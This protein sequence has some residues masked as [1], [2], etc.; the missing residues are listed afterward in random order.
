MTE[1]TFTESKSYKTNDGQVWKIYYKDTAD[2]SDDGA[3]SELTSEDVEQLSINS[4]A[5]H[6]TSRANPFLDS[7]IHSA[8]ARATVVHGENDVVL[9]ERRRAADEEE[10]DEDERDPMLSAGE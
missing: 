6:A 5:G 10:D 3:H 4:F 2:L 8:G 9:F 7:S 1:V